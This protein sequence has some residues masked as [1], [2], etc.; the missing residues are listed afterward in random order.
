VLEKLTVLPTTV[1]AAVKATGPMK[2]TVPAV[3]TAVP[4]TFSEIVVPIT[5]TLLPN[6]PVIVPFTAT[7]PPNPPDCIVTGLLN[8]TA[9][10]VTAAV[11]AAY[12]IVIPVLLAAIAATSASVTCNPGTTAAIPMLVPTSA[13]WITT[14]LLVFT[15]LAPP[16]SVSVLPVKDSAPNFTPAVP[17]FDAAETPPATVAV[18]RVHPATLAFTEL[19]N[20]TR[21]PAVLN[22]ALAPMVSTPV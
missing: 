8:V 13:G 9:F 20:V 1:V 15:V 22:T 3:V 16:D 21:L 4:T 18:V 5:A 19:E 12:P 2:V 6:A 17:M 10:T 7:L 11:P 14:V